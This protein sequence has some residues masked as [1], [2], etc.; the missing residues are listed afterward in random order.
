MSETTTREP[1]TDS[2]FYYAHLMII[3]VVVY[4]V[5]NLMFRL[6]NNNN[7][8]RSNKSF[9][10][11]Y[12]G[13]TEK[14]QVIHDRLSP[15]QAK[16]RKQF[17]IALTLVKAAYWVKSPYIYALYNRLHKFTRAEIGILLVIENFSCLFFGPIIGSLCDLYGRKK[18]S[19]MYPILIIAHI[20]MR[21][22]GI[23][24]LAVLA[25][26]TAGFASILIDSAFESWLNFEAMLLFPK[27]SDGD[28]QKN[29]YLREVFTKQIYIDC[30]TSIVLSSIA[31]VLYV[32]IKV[33][34]IKY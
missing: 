1:D 5:I 30:L 33:I 17:L 16:L 25:Q 6:I 14:I 10:F 21:L 22:T 26:I 31:T 4:I 28:K 27:N 8:R 19:L 34:Y 2:I 29:S 15:P 20:L 11:D 32:S 12:Y 18:F 7:H 3:L 23:R 13:K 9:S 24:P